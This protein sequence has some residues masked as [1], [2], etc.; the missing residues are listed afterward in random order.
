MAD[1]KVSLLAAATTIG[2]TD[3]LYVAVG[4]ASKR[5]TGA[6]A[7][8]AFLPPYCKVV[9]QKAEGVNGGS[10]TNNAWRTRDLNTEEYDPAG[11]AT[12]SAN[13][14]TLIA[15]TY[16]CDIWVPAYNVNR[17]RA[18]LRN[19]TD[20]ANVLMG[21][22]GMNAG[23]S[24]FTSNYARISG[25]FT[26]AASKALEI[27]HICQTTSNTYGFGVSLGDGGGSL[28]G[29]GVEVYTEAEFWLIG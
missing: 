11:L 18:R 12:I 15:G 16:R 6:D 24:G 22:S 9:D 2:A 28:A 1:S 23:P 5:I 20:G 21:S 29:Q 13:Q 10:F 27:Q 19:V 17:H 3:D 26:I 14:I 25:V 8:L 7:K 4:G